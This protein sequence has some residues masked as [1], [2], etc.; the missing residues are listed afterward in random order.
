MENMEDEKKKKPGIFGQT[1]SIKDAMA[2]PRN[3]SLKKTPYDDNPLP[4]LDECMMN[5]EK[6]KSTEKSTIA[7]MTDFIEIIIKIPK[8]L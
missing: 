6:M 7:Q 3:A 1:T 5:D 2:R 4:L 8:N